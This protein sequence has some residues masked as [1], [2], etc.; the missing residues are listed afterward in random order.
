MAEPTLSEITNIS[1]DPER[2]TGTPAVVTD[3]SAI[4]KYANQFAQQKAENDWRKYAVFSERLKDTFKELGEMKGMPVAQ[5]DRPLLEKKSAEIFKKIADDPQG[6]FGGKMADVEKGIGELRGLSTQSVQ[7]KI[8]NDAHRMYV[9]RDPTL[10]ISDNK[11][12]LDGYLKQPLGTRKAYSLKLPSLYNPQEIGNQI[13]AIIPQKFAQTGL[14]P[15]G[16]YLNTVSGIRYDEKQ[17]RTLADQMYNSPDQRGVIISSQVADR[18][19]SLPPQLQQIYQKKYPQDPVKGFYDETVMPWKKP[20]QIES[21]KQV[22]DPFAIQGFKNKAKIQEMNLKFGFDK[23][24]ES[25]KIGGA[26]EVEKLKSKLRGESKYGKIGALKVMVGKMVDDAKTG[27]PVPTS[28]G[29]YYKI[30]VSEPT[31]KAYGHI[32][33]ALKKQVN[34][35]DILVSE[36]GEKMKAVFYKKKGD[37]NSGIDDKKTKTFSKTEFTARFGKET[38]GVS[39]TEKEINAPDE[40]SGDESEEEFPLPEGQSETVQQGGYTYTWNPSTGKYE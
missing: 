7:D 13:N 5:E 1:V 14:S 39:A 30:G 6:F 29:T 15:D 34:L 36:D 18:F 2:G 16:K 27:T 24:I 23:A 19:K 28:E 10:N 40:E 22:G 9:D 38:L 12:L 31:L 25:M 4:A 33:G 17:Y 8:F 32:E 37:P 21:T 35:D 26:K 3:S 11:S 20:D